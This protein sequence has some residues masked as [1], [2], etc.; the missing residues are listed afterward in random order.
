[1]K[2]LIPYQ[3]INK[4]D[5]SEGARIRKSIKGALELTG[6]R[7]TSSQVDNYDVAHFFMPDDIFKASEAKNNGNLVVVSAFMA[8]NNPQTSFLDYKYNDGEIM[9]TLSAK[10]EKLLKKAD[11]VLIPSKECEKYLNDANIEA[12]TK[13]ILPG[14]N[15]AR[16]DFSREDEKELFYRYYR[17]DKDKKLVLGVGDYE[18]LEGINAFY[19]AAKK[20]K[21]AIFYFFGQVRNPKR[22]PIKVM[23]IM[24]KAPKNVFFAINTNDDIYRSALLNASILMLP[25]Y[26]YASVVTI[27]E[28]MSAKCNI[29]AR[30]QALFEDLLENNE[31]AYLAR[32]SETLATLTR[33]LLE[34]N[35]KPTAIKAYEA[36]KKYN[37][38]NIGE[39]LKN[40]YQENL[41]KLGE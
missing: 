7:Y 37:L 16:F 19:E 29:V 11:V 38:K 34:G 36:V 27:L 31:T 10:S 39:E 3:P 1:M 23:S 40:C 30:E 41:D 4:T 9:Y 33:D 2:V 22:I 21:D 24:K 18:T 12:E 13:I 32:F 20:C 6:V 14:V 35:I 25:L 15:L 8:E 26:R 5:T 28:A 17:V